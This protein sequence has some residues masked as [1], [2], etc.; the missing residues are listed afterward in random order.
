MNVSIKPNVTEGI[1]WPN[2][3][4]VAL[5]QPDRVFSL[6]KVVQGQEEQPIT[7]VYDRLLQAA[8]ERQPEGAKVNEWMQILCDTLPF[9]GEHR[10]ARLMLKMF[11]L[12]SP[13]TV[14]AAASAVLDNMIFEVMFFDATNSY[15]LPEGMAILMG[16]CF[17]EISEFLLPG[18]TSVYSM[19][20]ELR[21]DHDL[22]QSEE[23]GKVF[24]SRMA[25]SSLVPRFEAGETL[26]Y[27]IDSLLQIVTNFECS[28]IS[29]EASEQVLEEM[30]QLFPDVVERRAFSLVQEYRR[31]IDTNISSRSWEEIRELVDSYGFATVWLPRG[32]E[33]VEQELSRWVEIFKSGRP[34]HARAAMIAVSYLV[35]NL[36]QDGWGIGALRE[37]VDEALKVVGHGLFRDPGEIVDLLFRR[38][39]IASGQDPD[40]AYCMAS[41]LRD[42]AVEI[43]E[44][45]LFASA[46]ATLFGSMD[47]ARREEE[48]A[49]LR[50]L[51]D[52]PGVTQEMIG[53]IS[54]VLERFGLLHKKAS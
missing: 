25:Y 47:E 6:M 27:E 12:A 17:S 42:V 33:C 46:Y 39:M 3:L 24:F 34:A 31:E 45:S 13:D 11:K 18:A 52:S 41:K 23:N 53:A 54:S 5:A 40:L 48:A 38:I 30:V 35:V 43:N 20:E 51:L 8:K 29:K 10:R 28:E 26:D 1:G 44:P 49:I 15:R 4:G 7:S 21:T 37:I 32:S 9:E 36:L 50:G 16:M 2:A 22:L 14:S 19:A